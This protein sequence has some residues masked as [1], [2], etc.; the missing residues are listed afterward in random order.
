MVRKPLTEPQPRPAPAKI[1]R[2]QPAKAPAKVA[3]KAPANAPARPLAKAAPAAPAKAAPK[4]PAKAAGTPG[5]GQRPSSRL[6]GI[7][8]G[9][10]TQPSQAKAPAAL[11]KAQTAEQVRQTVQA[12]IYAE[13]RPIFARRAPNGTDIEKLVTLVEV[14]VNPDGTLAGPPRFLSQSGKTES[15]RPQQQLHVEE[16]I[17]SVRLAAP[18]NMSAADF[19]G[20]QTITLRFKVN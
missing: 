4:T 11:P 9:L 1:L 2:P 20:V 8:K 18:F 15:N 10:G 13:V 16:A 7:V 17:K 12:S 3:V 6:D 5:S 19:S 14:R